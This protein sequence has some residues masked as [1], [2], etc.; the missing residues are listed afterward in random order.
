MQKKGTNNS[1]FPSDNSPKDSQ[2]RKILVAILAFLA[3]PETKKALKTVMKCVVILL[4]IILGVYVLTLLLSV[5]FMGIQRFMQEYQDAVLLIFL[6]MGI[7]AYWW[8]ARDKPVPPPPP[9]PIDAAKL[10]EVAKR[11]RELATP[12]IFDVGLNSTALC[13]FSPL[14][15]ESEIY[16]NP[17]HT[18]VDS[19][20]TIL[21][22]D[23]VK[24]RTGNSNCDT[25]FIKKIFRQRLYQRFASG[26]IQ[27]ISPNFVFY[28][29][30]PFPAL[31][32]YDVVDKGLS[33]R[34]DV[35]FTSANNLARLD[36][37]ELAALEAAR[38]DCDFLD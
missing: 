16:H 2:S 33:I 36:A 5:A 8:F 30:R 4:L 25:D 3:K 19:N 11:Q 9:E 37:Q 29:A 34:V 26:K 18:I 21:H 14:M 12:H 32:I 28:N 31:I 17:P 13:G 22:Y 15:D 23:F 38:S 7:F 20:L 35:F 6:A 24:C 1:E 10:V 27:T